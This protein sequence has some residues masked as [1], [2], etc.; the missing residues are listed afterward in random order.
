MANGI[1]TGVSATSFAPNNNVTRAQ[2]VTFFHRVYGE[3]SAPAATF[4][5]MPTNQAFRNAISWANAEGIT[6]GMP[7]GSATFRPGNNMTREQMATMLH[8]HIGNGAAAPDANLGRFVD[9]ANI[10]SWS[11]E[12]MNW[13]VYHGLMGV[14]TTRLNPGG[15]ATRAETVAMLYRAV[16]TFNVSAP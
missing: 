2:F 9:N 4:S 12:A 6:T 5:D 1:T 3:P 13:V 15:N 8:R 11:R 14:N 16:D 10:S 7:A